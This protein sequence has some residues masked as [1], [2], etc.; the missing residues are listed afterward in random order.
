MATEAEEQEEKGVEATV[1]EGEEQAEGLGQDDKH[2]DQNSGNKSPENVSPQN[3]DTDTPV[4]SKEK[5]IDNE[6]IEES[7]ENGES[8]E[9]PA[10]NETSH[11]ASGSQEEQEQVS[12]NGTDVQD[13]TASETSPKNENVNGSIAVSSIKAS[14]IE[15]TAEVSV[16][17]N[18]SATTREILADLP[19]EQDPSDSALEGMRL[20]QCVEWIRDRLIESQ[21]CAEDQSFVSA[22]L[23]LHAI[24]DVCLVAGR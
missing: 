13:P 12:P 9:R 21:L 10:E 8:P 24:P 4:G 6:K 20:L 17:K 23:V 22:T 18:P 2:D 7:N 11:D 16:K 14:P 15:A 19:A 3:D 1:M 5:L